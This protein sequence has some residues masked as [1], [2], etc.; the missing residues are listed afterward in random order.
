MVSITRDDDD[1]DLDQWMMMAVKS[2][3]IQMM[4]DS[5]TSSPDPVSRRV[6]AYFD[7]GQP[8]S[9]AGT[10]YHLLD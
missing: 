2:L 10:I 7:P 3:L 5:D 1:D 6:R 9:E 8:D 4:M